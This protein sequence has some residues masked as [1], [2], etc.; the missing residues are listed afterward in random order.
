VGVVER[1]SFHS[2]ARGWK[3]LSSLDTLRRGLVYTRPEAL[4]DAL[5]GG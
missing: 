5:R 2:L 1:T 3:A 4:R